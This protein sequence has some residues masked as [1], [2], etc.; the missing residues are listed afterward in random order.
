MII[1]NKLW[2]VLIPLIIAF[3]L[4][5]F[6]T[7]FI[8]RVMKMADI[9]DKPIVSE[10]SHKKGTPIMGG[11]AIIISALFVLNVYHD[12]PILV[13]TVGLM[14]VSGIIGLLDD[15]IGLKVKEIQKVVKNI[16]TESVQLGRLLLKPGD[17]VRVATPKA[18]MEVQSLFDSNKVE[19]I[20]EI[21]I[22]S[23]IKESEKIFSQILIGIFLIASG[24]ISFT[25][26][27]M[28]LGLLVFPIA[29]LGVVGAINAV[30]L[31]D[32][33]DGLA[34]GIMGIASLSC[35]IFSL[36]VG[37]GDVA[38]TFFVLAGLCFGFLLYNRIPAS[39]FMGDTGAF[40]LGGGFAAAAMLGDIVPFAV[41]SITVPILSVVISL[42][43]RAKII[44]LPVEPLHHTLHYR[45]LSEGKI[46]LLYWSLTVLVC[47][48]AI[49]VTIYS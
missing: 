17:E 1:E 40:A 34:A 10:H 11:L 9:T 48:V 30:N 14:I 22:K 8:R 33:M 49:I 39:I 16:S 26:F 12:I 15:L 41:V 24:A 42:M 38:I 37:K 36:I 25:L 5:A 44:K 47:A 32:G 4:T 2:A 20:R 19:L 28:N 31:I 43:H 46:V 6:F 29:I 23:E 35:A 18:K 3:I 7:P 27:G 13:L 21:P 45:G